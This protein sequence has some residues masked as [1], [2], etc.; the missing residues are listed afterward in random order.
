MG[1]QMEPT[2]VALVGRVR[3]GDVGAFNRLMARWERPVYN[4]VYRVVGHDEDARDLVQETILRVYNGLA[5]LQDPNKFPAWL[6]RIAHNVCLD[7]LRSG[8]NR[9]MVSTDALPEG[10][11]DR[12]LGDRP[13]LRRADADPEQVV[14]RKEIARILMRALQSLSEE[15]RT[16]VV[17]R[18]YN[19]Y[20]SREIA[21][22]LGIPVGTVR[23]R[24][25]HG[26]R[27]LNRLLRRLGTEEGRWP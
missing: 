6:F 10:G 12:L 22:I 14:Y 4:F 7:R 25:F 3:D 18:E 21:E 20:S 1:Q 24:I 11:L 23:S 9:A 27:N 5:R 13:D 17:M 16:A 2:D 26:L 15:Q 8:K 19:G